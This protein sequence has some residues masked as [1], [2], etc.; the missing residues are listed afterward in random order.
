MTYR[1]DSRFIDGAEYITG[2]RLVSEHG[3]PKDYLETDD[4]VRDIL[5]ENGKPR[6]VIAPNTRFGMLRPDGERDT[7]R[8]LI[9]KRPLALSAEEVRARAAA[10]RRAA[11]LK[12]LP[13]IILAVADGAEFREEIEKALR[14][15]REDT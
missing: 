4:P 5:D 12:A 14:K 6:W 10:A 11:V 3:T 7:R 2:Y 13:D 9:E 15:D 1:Y 8:H